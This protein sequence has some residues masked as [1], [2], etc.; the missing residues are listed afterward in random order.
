MITYLSKYFYFKVIHSNQENRE[1]TG[2]TGYFTDRSHSMF[3]PPRVITR[4]DTIMMI[5]KGITMFSVTKA[6]QRKMLKNVEIL[7]GF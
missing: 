4:Q 5:E 1:V 7:G 6:G 3:L 2:I